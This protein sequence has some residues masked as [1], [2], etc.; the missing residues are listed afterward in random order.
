MRIVVNLKRRLGI[1]KPMNAVNNGP[2]GSLV[3]GTGNAEKY[4]ALKIPNYSTY[5]IRL[6]KKED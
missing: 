5:F 2:A 1:I 6:T 3:R 4:A